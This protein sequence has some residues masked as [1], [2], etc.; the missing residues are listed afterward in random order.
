MATKLTRLT[1][2]IVMQLYVVA[3]SYTVCSYGSRRPVRKLLNISSY[4]CVM[5]N[6]Y[7]LRDS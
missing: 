7:I 3:Q 5:R 4:H 2:K 1:H 6:L